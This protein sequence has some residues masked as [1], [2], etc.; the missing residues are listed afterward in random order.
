MKYQAL[1]HMGGSDALIYTLLLAVF[2]IVFS[3]SFVFLCN[4]H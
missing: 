4:P 1:E 2:I 3:F